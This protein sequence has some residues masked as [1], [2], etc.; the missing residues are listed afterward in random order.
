MASLGQRF[1]QDARLQ[2]VQDRLDALQCATEAI[3]VASL[4]FGR[5]RRGRR[6]VAGVSG[7]EVGRGLGGAVGGLRPWKPRIMFYGAAGRRPKIAAES[8]ERCDREREL[9]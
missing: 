6:F 5:P 4:R 7:G 9:E 2:E 1:L 8:C 3:A